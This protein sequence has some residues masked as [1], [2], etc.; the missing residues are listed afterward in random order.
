VGDADG[1]KN[2]LLLWVQRTCKGYREVDP[3]NV[4]NFTGDWNTG[5]PFCAIIHH[6][7]PDL[8]D[9]DSLSKGNA[10]A[11]CQLAF[12][13]AEKHLGIPRLLDA[14]D[15]ANVARPD[16]K[17]I[18]AYV[19]QFFKL[20]AKA[21]KN[22]ALIKSIRTAIDVTKRHDAWILKYNQQA[23]TVAEFARSKGAVLIKPSTGRTTEAVKKELDAF[24]AYMKSEK[25]SLQAAR[26]EADG[27]ATQLA[28]SKRN[29]KRP[30]FKPEIA[31][32]VLQDTWTALEQAELD[33][34]H[35]LLD[36]YTRFRQVD[37]ESAKFTGR[38]KMAESWFDE[39]AAA[40][41][42]GV[43]SGLSA[44]IDQAAASLGKGESDVADAIRAKMTTL[45]QKL[46]SVETAGTA[47]R[48]ALEASFAE[49]KEAQ[50]LELQYLRLADGL[51][52]DVDQ[53][54]TR[55]KE[56][57]MVASAKDVTALSGQVAAMRK[58]IAATLAQLDG[59]VASIATKLKTRRPAF[60]KHVDEL[61]ARLKGCEDTLKKRE[62]TLAQALQE[63]TNKDA[64]RDKFAATANAFGAAVDKLNAKLGSIDGSLEK[65]LA[66]VAAVREQVVALR[67]DLDAISDL[68]NECAKQS[69]V[70]NPK[71]S[72]TYFTLQA[73]YDQ[74]TKAAAEQETSIS[75]QI[76]AEKAME[77]S[78]E[79]MKEFQ[80]VF[81]FFD[82]DKTGTMS[83]HELKEACTAV[84]IDLPESEVER[85]MR[86][87]APD[88]TFRVDDFIKFMMSEVK[89]G[90]TLEH[91][92]SAFSVFADGK[93]RV[94]KEQLDSVLQSEPDLNA[95][96]AERMPDG[97][98]NAF[99]NDLFSR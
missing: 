20:F 29:N 86:D 33:H 56:P 85:R 18:V 77:I 3:P 87:M 96:I 7:R 70:A 8:I 92:V 9:Y 37:N 59:E 90:S 81:T 69:I 17:S 91:V 46:Q 60:V 49:E 63:E 58:D 99:A 66:G 31:P 62:A 68:S 43:K 13:V 82:A 19:S 94:S 44:G 73:S 95:Y 5:M 67:G 42:A 76:M 22:D 79:Q 64:I 35:A 10:L 27:V 6:F 14:E 88:M 38:A 75:A 16:E 24:V 39:R 61:K 65:Q 12:S 15:V 34:E 52:F 26:A 28:T 32:D 83:L 55:V 72:H 47:H 1:G 30:E 74:L 51:D 48:K 45:N 23:K 93:D 54:D 11:N 98:F 41:K 21:S 2:G 50:K 78:P 89:A 4:Q 25:P 36:K 84:G 71:T 40:F 53:L 80:E 57:V 97:D